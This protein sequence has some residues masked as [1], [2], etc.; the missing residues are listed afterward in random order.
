M[1]HLNET[2]GQAGSAF[3]ARNDICAIII[4]PLQCRRKQINFEKLLKG[5]AKL[6]VR[7]RDYIVRNFKLRE[8]LCIRYEDWAFLRTA[9]FK[10]KTTAISTFSCLG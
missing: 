2:K 6:S 9:G 1:K 10:K 8:V 3:L 5:A 4:R 7:T